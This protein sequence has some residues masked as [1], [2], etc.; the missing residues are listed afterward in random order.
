M[1]TLCDLHMAAQHDPQ[2]LADGGH[3]EYAELR[4]LAGGSTYFVDM[5]A[6][7][8]VSLDVMPGR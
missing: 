3:V 5:D 8:G 4:D 7:S 1:C 2:E 6:G